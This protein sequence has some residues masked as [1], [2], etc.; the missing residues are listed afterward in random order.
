MGAAIV[1]HQLQ[2]VSHFADHGV[3]LRAGIQFSRHAQLLAGS[4]RGQR[5]AHAGGVKVVAAAFD[6]EQAVAVLADAVAVFRLQHPYGGEVV[7]GEANPTAGGG[8]L[9]VGA[10]AFTL[11]IVVQ[12]FKRHFLEFA[13][14]RVGYR[15]DIGLVEI[16]AALGRTVVAQHAVHAVQLQR[17]ISVVGDIEAYIDEIAAFAEGVHFVHL[18]AVGFRRA[19]AHFQR[20]SVEGVVVLRGFEAAVL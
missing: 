14:G 7:L 11:E 12:V 19:Q 18:N 16:A 5:H 9:V 3:L 1:F 4:N 17:G 10:V 2:A 6:I 13:I 8:T 15:A 20:I